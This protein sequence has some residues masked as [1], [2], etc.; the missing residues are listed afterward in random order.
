MIAQADSSYIIGAEQDIERIAEAIKLI[1]IEHS[2]YPF[3]FALKSELERLRQKQ[4]EVL[5]PCLSK[6]HLRAHS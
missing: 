3:A 5:T 4:P 2:D 1:V 6:I